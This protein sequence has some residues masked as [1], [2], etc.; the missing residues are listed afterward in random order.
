MSKTGLS[1]IG[2][3]NKNKTHCPHG[4]ELKGVNLVKNLTKKGIRLC[5]ICVNDRQRKL[6]SINKT[7]YYELNIEKHRQFVRNWRK[8]NPGYQKKW[9]K[10]NPLK[11]SN[12]CKTYALKNIDKVKEK[13]KRFRDQ[14]PEYLQNWRKNNPRSPKY[15]DSI[16]LQL[17]MN[18]VRKR[19]HNTCQWAKC[20]LTFRQAPIHVHHIFPRSEYPDLAE[21]E[22]YMICYCAN[23]HGLWHMYRGDACANLILKSYYRVKEKNV[24][25]I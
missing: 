22:Q 8:R 12:Y 16:D 17:A 6:W 3:I 14:H 4:H 21:I 19:D 25:V 9:Y 15:D 24:G 5:R 20:G 1:G 2:L 23:H 7:K 13:N 18:N 10:K 11:T